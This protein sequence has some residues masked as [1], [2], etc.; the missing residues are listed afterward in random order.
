MSTKLLKLKDLKGKFN[1]AN[2]SVKELIETGVKLDEQNKNTNSE[3]NDELNILN[4]KLGNGEIDEKGFQN[5]SKAI[6]DQ[7]KENNK[8]L[9]NEIEENKKNIINQ[10]S[11][12]QVI[13]KQLPANQQPTLK[14]QFS[15][16][17]HFRNFLGND[18]D[19]QFVG[20]ACLLR[21]GFFSLEIHIRCHRMSKCDTVTYAT[22][23]V[24]KF[25]RLL[26]ECN[27]ISNKFLVKK[28]EINSKK[29]MKMG[30]VY[31]DLSHMPRSFNIT[32]EGLIKVN[33]TIVNRTLGLTVEPTRDLLKRCQSSI[34]GSFNF[35]HFG[36]IIRTP[37]NLFAQPF[38]ENE[39]YHLI[40]LERKE[41]QMNHEKNNTKNLIKRIENLRNEEKIDDGQ[42]RN[43][44]YDLNSTRPELHA[45]VME[46]NEKAVAFINT[47]LANEPPVDLSDE[48]DKDNEFHES[49]K[50][51][52]DIFKLK[53]NYFNSKLG[54]FKGDR[55]PECLK[56]RTQKKDPSKIIAEITRR[57]GE[58]EKIEKIGNKNEEFNFGNLWD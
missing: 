50:N 15:G 22:G 26:L 34:L 49:M 47:E 32:I 10:L 24:F 51:K 8:N 45:M 46:I 1:I 9:K 2:D 27:A 38:C 6:Q 4:H 25:E 57:L 28:K 54:S 19:I 33:A 7:T 48:E 43:M 37:R 39:L 14:A 12:Q 23:I 55:C 13:V 42:M 44:L 11:I 20:D 17:P 16:D 21:S 31:V 40:D 3:L 36:K 5:K 35:T 52:I 18:F 58:L 53:L 30:K 56:E 41:M 29:L